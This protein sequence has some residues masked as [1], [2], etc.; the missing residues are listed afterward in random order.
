M[1]HPSALRHVLAAIAL[2]AAALAA[3]D[4]ILIA[5]FEGATYGGW[6]TT[7]EAFGPGPARGTLAG[8]M[9]VS[10]FEGTGL[11]NSFFEGDG[12]VGTL[13]S[14]PFRIERRF[15]TF[16]VG[17]GMHPGETCINLLAGGAIV[18]TATG[19]N[20]KP[21]GSERL[22]W[23][24]WDVRD[25]EGTEA[26][27]EIVDRATGG[28]GHVNVDHIVQSDRRA[29]V[30]ERV[31]TL[32]I[33]REYLSFCIPAHAGNRAQVALLVGGR[34]VRHA[35]GA[36]R[37][38]ASWITWDV[39]RLKGSRGE[40]RV[41]EL[42][43]ADG[44]CPL[45]GSVSL[46]SEV[47]GALIVVDKLYRETYRPQFHFSPAA[48]WTNDPNG[49]V[50]YD[51]EYHLFFQ[52]NPFGID[53]GNMTWG[54]AVSADLLHWTQLEHALR[55]DKLGTMFSGSAVVD[56]DDTAGF[57]KGG[58]KTLVA[59]Y[60]AAGGTSRESQGQPF[61]QCIAYSN[62]RGRTWTKHDKNPVLGH[63]AGGNRDPKV[64]RHAPTGQWVMALYLD[65]DDFALFSSPDLKTWQKLCDVPMPGTSECPD[66]FELPVDGDARNTRW[67]FWGGNGNYRLGAFDGRR[68]LPETP[69]LRSRYG[70]NDY[71]AQTY[72]DIPASDGRRIQ[73]TWMQGGRYPGM[74]FNQQMGFPRVLT[75]GST[76]EGVRLFFNP[77]SEIE[78]LRTDTRTWRALALALGT[79]PLAALEGELWDIDAVLEPKDA[80]EVG[81]V[82]RGA[83]IAYDA[84]AG[85]L[86][87]PGGSAPLAPDGGRIAL[88]ILVDR[89]SI[90]V[91]AGGGRRLICFCFL[92]DPADRSLDLY[93]KGGDAVC[94]AL[95]VSALR[96]TWPE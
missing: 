93:A 16:L 40:L 20:D 14:P 26:V 45:A 5:D 13:V 24:S 70:A 30:V 4:D 64:I 21:G 85:E 84:K 79:N 57:R 91:F 89:S 52:H 90:E 17:G 58:E 81:V 15:I 29:G 73:I 32:A 8:Q 92:P 3:R 35:A 39:S 63:I 34:V 69:P 10:G 9:D 33:D 36:D 55:P 88:R 25:L 7:G 74:P 96:S 67:V 11:V 77:I 95:R 68:F 28:W 65:G 49:L 48:N 72:S 87:T 50:F 27:I 18:R 1:N 51:G 38:T 47:K 80:A 19:P 31:S 6:K 12:T 75:L 43:A 46:G 82:V 60:T 59:I 62:D 54:H 78:T 76:P 37:E 41:S 61:T 71:A 94:A 53:W 83:R 44:A 56:H 2:A 22:D 66:F 42:P 23:H 86:R